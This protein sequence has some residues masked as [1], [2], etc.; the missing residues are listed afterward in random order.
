MQIYEHQ[1][2]VIEEDPKKCLIAFG[3]GGGK[4]FTC[5]LLAKGKTL[6][7][8]PKQQKIDHTW[9]DNASKFKIQIDLTVVSKEEFRRDEKK[10]ERFDTVIIDECHT[11]LGVS[12]ETRQRKGVTVPKASQLFDATVNFI[13]RTNPERLYLASATPVTNPM[14]L[15]AIL[16]LLGHRINFYEFRERYYTQRKMGYRIIWTPRNTKELRQ[17]LADK[18]R[19]IGYTGKLADWFDVPE[20]THTTI[21]VELSKEQRE[22]I[23]ELENTEADPMGLRART[24]AIENGVLYGMDV[25]SEDSTTDIIRRSTRYFKNE[26]L[27]EIRILV[28]EFPKILIFAAYTGQIEAIRK[29]LVESGCN[30]VKTVT[31]ETRDRSTIFKE[32]EK[33]E[34]AT[35]ICQASI[36]SGY[37][38]PSFPCVVFASKSYSYKDFEQGIGRVLRANAIK[39][40]LYV[41][42]VVKDGVDHDCHKA[43]MLGQDFQERLMK[44]I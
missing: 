10:L 38:L 39:K 34:E 17:R 13:K 3:T 33:A 30:H 28:S 1:K 11:I 31:G 37:E 5:L 29:Y 26:K 22:A 9:E 18:T 35:L 15:Y 2:K 44:K 25:F 19:A 36:S 16:I 14:H 27:E 6:V 40:N 7:I 8:C 20:Q 12:P 42:L 4:T 43:I 24:R 21:Y 41:H 23:T 32:V